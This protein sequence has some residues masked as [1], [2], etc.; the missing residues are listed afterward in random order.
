MGSDMGLLQL[1]P[2]WLMNPDTASQLLPLRPGM[3]DVVIFDEA[4]QIPVENAL[5][6]LYRAKRA[7]I[8]GDE[9]QMPPNTVFV[10]RLCEDDAESYDGELDDSTSEAERADF[11]DSWNQREIKDCPTC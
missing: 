7:I 9:K 3:F 4:S 8:S 10:K 1:R 2:V 6:A 5:P 11:E